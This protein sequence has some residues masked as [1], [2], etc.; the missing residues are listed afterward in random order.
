[1]KTNIA[2]QP[3]RVASVLAHQAWLF[4]RY[5]GQRLAIEQAYAMYRHKYDIIVW[6]GVSGSLRQ[7][8][9]VGL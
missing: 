2:F 3:P 4:P 9:P 6:L 8:S 7:A 5:L 1:M